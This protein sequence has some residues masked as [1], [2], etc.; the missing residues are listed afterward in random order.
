MI[1]LRSTDSI[2]VTTGTANALD[3]AATYHDSNQTT[4]DPSPQPTQISSAT[5]TTIVSSPGSGLKRSV[6]A[7]SFNA[8]GG[9]N[10]VIVDT[11]DSSNAS[12]IIKAT[13]SQD[14][15]LIYEDGAGWMLIT[16]GA[17]KTIGTVSGVD[18]QVFK[19]P[20]TYTWTKPSNPKRTR[21]T[22]FPVGGPGASGRK[23]VT[24]G[25]SGGGG[26][27]GANVAPKTLEFDSAELGATETV[28][29]GANSVG[30]VAQTTNDT[31]G[32]AGTPGGTTSFG[33][34]LSATAGASGTGGTTASAAAGTSQTGF[35]GGAAIT[36]STSGAGSNSTGGTGI[37]STSTAPS[38]A[39][40]GGGVSNLGTPS[41]GGP[42]GATS[43]HAAA[44]AGTVGAGQDGAN[45]ADAMSLG[46]TPMGG[47]GGGGGAGNATG[48]KAGKGGKGGFPSGPGGGGG[49]SFGGGDSGDGGDGGGALV[50]AVTYCGS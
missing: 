18:V 5:T 30:G 27:A 36:P 1:C 19:T 39:G 11:F 6:K 42:G 34:W 2:R 21:V 10:T 41:N 24:A 17:I 7:L 15:S 49:G 23:Q 47:N 37:A 8:R 4:F 32:I 29:I 38:G 3:V 33:S 12:R 20:G 44:S 9:S 31:A 50:I 25:T 48:A 16:G 22:I 26:G 14:D 43:L 13:L 28:T 40:G 35:E 45:G 46:T